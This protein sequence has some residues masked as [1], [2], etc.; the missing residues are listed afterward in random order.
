[1][2]DK[3]EKLYFPT[4]KDI[5]ELARRENILR[6]SEEY[7]AECDRVHEEINGWLRVTEEAQIGLITDYLREKTKNVDQ[8]SIDITL[9]MLRRAQVLYPDEPE[10]KNLLYVKHNRAK[11]GVYQAGDK[12]VNLPIHQLDLKIVPLHSILDTNTPVV[13]F[14]GSHS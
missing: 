12:V 7:I 6:Y 14:A 13:I 4:K 11:V 10:I 5:L 3:E 9:N 1:M 2:G 8:I